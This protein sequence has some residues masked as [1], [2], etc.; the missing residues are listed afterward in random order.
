MLVAGPA[1]ARSLV[2]TLG[3]AQELVGIRPS[4]GLSAMTDAIAKDVTTSQSSPGSAASAAPSGGAIDSSMSILGPIFIPHAQTLGAGKWNLNALAQHVNLDNVIGPGPGLT[5]L[6]S[7]PTTKPGAA[8]LLACRMEYDL[9]LRLDAIALAASYGITDRL[10]ASVVLPITHSSLDAT[11]RLDILRKSLGG[12][13]VRTKVPT[14]ER[15]GTPVDSTG[16]GDMVFR[17]KYGLAGQRLGTS[18]FPLAAA[19]SVEWQFPTGEFDQMHGTGD[20]WITPTLD[21]AVPV[22]GVAEIAARTALDVDLSDNSRTQALYSLGASA[23]VIPRHLVVVAEFLGRSQ[24]RDAT[25]VNASA[26][27][28]LVRGRLQ[29]AA[30]LGL[31]VSRHDYFDFSFGIRVPVAPGIMAFASG[32]VALNGN[33]GLR[34]SGVTPT[35]GIGGNF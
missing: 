13:F 26:V 30:A 25:D 2:G 17:L 12:K 8:P 10:D 34:P 7:T 19:V 33:V 24:I 22:F 27:L 14:I 4:A 5:I 29:D 35:V 18:M 11:V 32:L 6:R 21:L 1:G 28:T 16:P 20:Y 23:I 31:D 15:S 9:K 3:D